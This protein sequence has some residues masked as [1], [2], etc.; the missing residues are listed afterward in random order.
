MASIS[1]TIDPTAAPAPVAPVR[2]PAPN[3]RRDL[4]DQ[5]FLIRN[6]DWATYRK[7]SDALNERHYY[8]SF[9]GSNLELMTISDP[10]AQFRNVLGDFVVVLTEETGQ[11]R[12]SSGDM[13]MDREDLERAIEAD[14]SFYIASEPKVRGR[15]IDLS[16]DPP[17]DLAIEI[18]LTTDSRRRFGI[19]GK[20]AVPEIWRYNG[21][22]LTIHLRMPDGKYTSAEHSQC[23]GF[24]AAADLT[25]FLAQLDQMDEGSL[26][27]SFRKWVR[28]QLGKV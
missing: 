4:G 22:Q 18:D 17:P 14:E 3:N 25:R 11:P 19:Y 24:L 16:T 12:R 6:I 26:V 21:Q 20:I 23:F 15:K 27:L 5:R 7:I 2:T 9:D 28:E 10:H 1:Q 13:T 8:M